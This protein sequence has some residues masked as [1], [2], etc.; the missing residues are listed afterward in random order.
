M[1]VWEV[2]IQHV[3]VEEICGPVTITR[4][5]RS[6]LHSNLNHIIVVEKPEPIEIAKS[7]VQI[8]FHFLEIFNH[9]PQSSV[10]RISSL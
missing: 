5:V 7:T 8:I 3:R 4:L 6:F 1:E 10:F 9:P 2:F